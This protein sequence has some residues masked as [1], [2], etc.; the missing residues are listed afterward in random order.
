MAYEVSRGQ[1]DYIHQVTLK[2][3]HERQKAKG[4][5]L[6][7]HTQTTEPNPPQPKDDKS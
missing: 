3:W 5:Q 7:P 4:A 1:Y 2:G 6:A